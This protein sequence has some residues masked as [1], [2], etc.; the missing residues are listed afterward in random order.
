MHAVKDEGFQILLNEEIEKDGK[1]WTNL[2]EL[3]TSNA[4][5]R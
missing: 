3:A 5:L 4:W 2:R 1:G